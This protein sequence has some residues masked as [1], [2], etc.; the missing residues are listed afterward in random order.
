MR[1]GAS[2]RAAQLRARSRRGAGL[3][4]GP[5]DR[6]HRHVE[7]RH[8]GPARF[9]RS[10]CALARALRFPAARLPDAGG[11][12]KPVKFTLSWLKEHLDTDATL[13]EIVAKLTMIGLEVESVE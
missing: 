7:I 5:G 10:R 1:H 2:E 3:C 6:P 13:D 8:A 11:R 4:L 12:A 9:L